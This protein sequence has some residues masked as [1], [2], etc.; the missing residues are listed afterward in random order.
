VHVRVQAKRVRTRVARNLSRF[1]KITILLWAILGSGMYPRSPLEMTIVYAASLAA[2]FGFAALLASIAFTSPQHMSAASATV[3]GGWLLIE[4]RGKTSEHEVTSAHAYENATELTTRNGES[5][6]FVHESAY[7]ASALVRELGFGAEGRRAAFDMD[8]PT[9]I[10]VR[11]GLAFLSFCGAMAVCLPLAA[12]GALHGAENALLYV[13]AA[14]LYQ[15]ARFM[16]RPPVVT[17]GVDGVAVMRRGRTRFVPS[18]EIAG[19]SFAESGHALI[20]RRD[21]T[22]IEVAGPNAFR[23]AALATRIGALGAREA[24]PTPIVLAR[25]GRGVRAWRDHLRDAVIG[26]YR[27]AAGSLDALAHQ[28]T[29]GAST[30]EDRIGAALALRVADEETGATR[31]RVAAEQCADDRLREALEIAA[32][33]EIDDAKLERALSRLA[34]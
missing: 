11:V 8:L 28:L 12:T 21:G 19:V 6:A 20:D 14:L 32:A 23:Q 7:E 33:R 34:K 5:W 18:R 3:S 29:S 17:A 26:G 24:A 13:V 27:V 15:S 10:F 9:T 31:V 22:T 25:Q 1:G 4:H 16:I 30:P 2:C